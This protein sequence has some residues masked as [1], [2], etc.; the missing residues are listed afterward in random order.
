M[1]Y[2]SFDH[3][4]LSSCVTVCGG[5]PV[6]LAGRNAKNQHCLEGSD[7]G[8][9]AGEE[10]ENASANSSQTARRL[11]SKGLAENFDDIDQPYPESSSAYVIAFAKIHSA[12]HTLYYIS[13]KVLTPRDV[14]QPL[15][16]SC[17]SD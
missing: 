7:S 15:M 1:M 11:N 12:G 4:I 3:I 10:T 8:D 9:L 2:I 14:T 5:V 13:E 17:A 16:S 6:A